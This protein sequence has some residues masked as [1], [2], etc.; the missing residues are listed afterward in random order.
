VYPPCRILRALCL[1][2]SLAGALPGCESGSPA[3]VQVPPP[4]VTVSRPLERTVTDHETFT[5]RTEAIDAVQVRAR[6]SGYL[7]KINFQEGADVRQGDVL[8]EID[9][10][11]YKAQLD[12]D[13]A[14]LANARATVTQKEALYRRTVVLVPKG[15][16]TRE[17]ADVQGG[18]LKIAEAAVEQAK[19]KI[20]LS[21]L[22][23]DWTRVTAPVSGRLSRTLLTRGNLVVADSTLLTTIVSLD[24]MY[25][26]FDVDEQSLLRVQQLIREGKFTSS[27]DRARDPALFAVT[28]VGFLAEPWVFAPLSAAAALYPGKTF[29]VVPVFL[30]LGNEEGYTHEGY[31]DFVNN[32]V[33]PS[34]GTLQI[35]GVLPNPR[36]AVGDRLLTPGL[37]VRVR[38]PITA[39][40]K[41]L[42]VNQRAVGADQGLSFVYVV[43]DKNEVVRREVTV[44]EPEDGLQVIEEGLKPDDRVIVSGVQRVRPGVVVNPTLV[45]MPLPPK[46]R[47]GDKVTR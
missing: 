40:H 14:T 22:N 6:V 25:A 45:D 19:A 33:D 9:P 46:R 7:D 21:Q 3:D 43:N 12:Q 47:Q 17:D 44:G 24:P 30:R 41:A 15:G 16:A 8:Y 4:P 18:D 5:G 2:G 26:Y 28:T 34:T 37:F 10:R 36:P 1:L 11:P 29:T 39:P 23:L 35:R 20:E 27:R 38:V 31:I 13:Q 42:L 32:R